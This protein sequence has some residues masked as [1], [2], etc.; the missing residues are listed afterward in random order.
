MIKHHKYVAALPAVLEADSIYYVRAGVGFDIYVTNSSGTVV[1][2]PV[3]PMEW[4]AETVGQDEAEAGTDTTRRAWTAERVRQAIVAWWNSVT[5]A[6]GREFVANNSAAAGRGA[7]SVREQLSAD[8]TYYV[9]TDGNN[10]NNG[11]I[12]SAGG[13]FATIQKA[14]DVAASLDLGIFNV[15]I[16]VADGTYAGGILLKSALGAGQVRIQGNDLFPENVVITS[17]QDSINGLSFGLYRLSGVTLRGTVR[18]I[19]VEGNSSYLEVGNIRFGAMGASISSSHCQ[20]SRGA[21]IAAVGALSFIANCAT[22][23]WS[24]LKATVTVRN[25]QISFSSGLTVSQHGFRG[26]VQGLVDAINVSFVGSFTGPRYQVQGLSLLWTNG[27]GE[28]FIPGSSA[29]VTESGGVYA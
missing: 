12:N 11:L 25:T 2:Y 23:A 9:R 4:S 24:N 16:Q 17:A 21:T 5:S 15:I 14:I 27:S 13:A 10:S 7:L 1:A 29:G 19:F 3:N 8:R 18:N 28:S 26:T 6:W 22:L 20:A